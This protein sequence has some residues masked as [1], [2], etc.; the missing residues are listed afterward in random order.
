[1]AVLTSEC[2]CPGGMPIP[3]GYPQRIRDKLDTGA[4]SREAPETI[5]SGFGSGQLCDGCDTPILAAQIEYQFEAPGNRMIK[6]HLGCAG[7]WEAYRRRSK[8]PI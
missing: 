6:F 8:S 2:Y 1:M 4:L 3:A 5:F 7:L